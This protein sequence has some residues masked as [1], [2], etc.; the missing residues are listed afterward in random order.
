VIDV[1]NYEKCLSD[2]L[3]GEVDPITRAPISNRSKS[4]GIQRIPGFQDHKLL[5]L[6]ISKI[7][8]DPQCEDWVE[9][10]IDEIK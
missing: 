6:Q 7:Q 10:I 3:G 9:I 8:K 4:H 2:F 5:Q 1:A